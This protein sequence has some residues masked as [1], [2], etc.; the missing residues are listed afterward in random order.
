MDAELYIPAYYKG[1]PETKTAGN[2]FAHCTGTSGL[3]LSEWLE[4]LGCGSFQ[5]CASLSGVDIP[6]SP[7]SIKEHVFY[8]CPSLGGTI[9]IPGNV[10]SIGYNASWYCYQKTAIHVDP[11]NV[12]LPPWTACCSIK[13]WKN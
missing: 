12:Y 11:N 8:D 1:I 13:G 4:E 7:T 6:E 3:H 10:A 5:L 9:E 2:G